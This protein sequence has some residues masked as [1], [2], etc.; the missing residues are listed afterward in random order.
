MML[1]NKVYSMMWLAVYPFI[2][3][4]AMAMSEDSFL[5]PFNLGLIFFIVGVVFIVIEVTTPGFFI[6]IPG[7]ILVITGLIMIY[8][9][10]VMSGS[11]GPVVFAVITLAVTAGMFWIYRYLAKPEPSKATTSMT[12]L[13]GMSGRVVKEIVPGELSGKVIVKNQT[14]SATADKRIPK[15]KKIIV[16][17]VDGVHLEVKEDNKGGKSE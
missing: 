7:S 10:W 1:Q 17:K 11:F 9:P 8:F 6:G 16:L 4:V 14:W 15:G 2:I 3:Q 13:V 12:N 5:S